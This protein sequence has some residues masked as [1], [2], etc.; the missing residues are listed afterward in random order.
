M[1]LLQSAKAK[2]PIVVTLSGMV[3]EVR[4]E[5][6][7]KAQPP[8]LVMASGMVIEARLLHPENVQPSML[9]TASGMVIEVR[10]L[11]LWKAEFP[12]LVTL[13]GMLMEARLLQSPEGSPLNAGNAGWDDNRS[14]VGAAIKG[15]FTNTGD[16]QFF[17]FIWNDQLAFS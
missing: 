15:A 7:M 8:M 9:V 13:S 6:A 4:L 14:Q 17:N 11:Q 3:V 1:R 16:Y 5:Q 10:L 2:S 12:I